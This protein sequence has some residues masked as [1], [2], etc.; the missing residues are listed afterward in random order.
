MKKLM[1]LVFAICAASLYGRT[2]ESEDDGPPQGLTFTSE[3]SVYRCGPFTYYKN[4]KDG[5]EVTAY[6]C[7]AI[8]YYS[9]GGKSL[10]TSYD[11]GQITYYNTEGFSGTAYDCGS[12]TYYTGFDGKSGGVAYG[13]NDNLSSFRS[14]D[15]KREGT[16]TGGRHSVIRSRIFDNED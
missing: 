15:G 8:T 9:S 2:Y 16:S 10:G 11:G 13:D 3:G 12:T 5:T 6:D 1:L 4:F 14:Y 7:G